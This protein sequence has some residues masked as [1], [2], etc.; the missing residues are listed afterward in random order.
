M[1]EKSSYFLQIWDGSSEEI[2]AESG[3]IIKKYL[4]SKANHFTF[5]SNR[6]RNY[7]KQKNFSVDKSVLSSKSFFCLLWKCDIFAA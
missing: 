1:W 7:E 2:S 4:A 5:I 3:G 6:F